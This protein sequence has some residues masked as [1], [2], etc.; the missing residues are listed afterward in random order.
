MCECAVVGANCVS[1][2]DEHSE[3]YGGERDERSED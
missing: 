3:C 1:V 2:C